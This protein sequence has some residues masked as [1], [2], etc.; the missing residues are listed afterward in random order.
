[1][2]PSLNYTIISISDNFNC[3]NPQ[4]LHLDYS[5]ANFRQYVMS[6]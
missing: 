5:E 4:S 2:D 6:F 3:L 1:M